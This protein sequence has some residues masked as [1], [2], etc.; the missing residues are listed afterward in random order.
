MSPRGDWI[1]AKHSD[2]RLLIYQVHN[3]REVQSLAVDTMEGALMATDPTGTYL[4]MKSWSNQLTVW[5]V[6]AG[7]IAGSFKV[8]EHM[9]FLTMSPHGVGPVVDAN[10][11]SFWKLEPSRILQSHDLSLDPTQRAFHIAVAPNSRLL[12]IIRSD[13]KSLICLDMET[14]QR[15]QFPGRWS[16][17]FFQ[18][19]YL[20]AVDSGVLYRWKLDTSEGVCRLSERERVQQGMGAAYAV[21]SLGNRI[22]VNLNG[23]VAI[24][25]LGDARENFSIRKAAGDVRLL[26]FS[27]D[28]KWLA[29]AGHNE[30]GCWIYATDG[31]QQWNLAPESYWTI[32][33]FSPNTKYLALQK[34]TLGLQL[35][36]V[37]R[38]DKPV[39]TWSG[40]FGFPA[41][42]P[43]SK[44]LATNFE[45]GVITILD[46]ACKGYTNR[47]AQFLYC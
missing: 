7:T 18:G 38:W 3:K 42:S 29:A 17:V 8:P 46:I 1:A 39:A 32:P 41:F 28:G 21:A 20:W 16:T 26:K 11:W 15:V 34:P 47:S 44:F 13:G 10:D 25:N 43:D 36:E 14:G 9:N 45:A 27:R 6:R 33:E 37:G 30:R 40:T 5:D 23:G 2:G 24:G 22:A 12:A 35:Y 19:D 4:A 31:E